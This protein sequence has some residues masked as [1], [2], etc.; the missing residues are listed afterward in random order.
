[1]LSGFGVDLRCFRTSHSSS[2]CVS[3]PHSDLLNWT[4]LKARPIPPSHADPLC[5][6]LLSLIHNLSDLG[7][8]KDYA[9]R[10]VLGIYSTEL[11]AVVS[12]LVTIPSIAAFTPASENVKTAHETWTPPISPPPK[13]KKEKDKGKAS[14]P[15][16]AP[17]CPPHSPMR[18]PSTPKLATAREAIGM[19]WVP[20]TNKWK[21]SLPQE[22]VLVKMAKTFPATTMIALQQVS[23]AVTGHQAPTPSEACHKHQKKYTTQGRSRKSVS[24]YSF[25]S[26]TWKE[27]VIF[28]QINGHLGNTKHSICHQNR[29]Q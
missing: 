5:T 19:S 8:L 14:A 18:P 24:V 11:G 9:S 6:S 3:S 4:I 27:N 16:P 1:M 7:V 21:T 26:F 12:N 23:S 2:F 29:I 25:P 15:T 10:D 22:E 20:I 17:P 28:N 13:R